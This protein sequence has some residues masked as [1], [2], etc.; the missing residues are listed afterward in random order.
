MEYWNNPLTE[1]V[2][3]SDCDPI[4]ESFHN[5]KH[6]IFWN[7]ETKFDNIL[8]NQRLGDLCSWAQAQLDHNGLD[9]FV[10]D[11]RNHYDIANLV[12]CN[13]WIH[14]IRSQGIV[15]PW[16]ML[17]LGDGTFIAGTGDSRLRCLERIPEISTV[18]GFISTTTA[19][20]HLYSD[21]EPVT[22]FDQYA[23]LCKA[24]PG[25]R[26]LFRL[27]DPTAP[28][29]VYWYEYDSEQTRLVTPGESDAVSMFYNYAK[30][31]PGLQITPEWFDSKITW[32]HHRSN[33]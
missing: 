11:Q 33:S 30:L 4:V 1:V 2:W 21:L 10:Q 19:R 13:L 12:K 6:C 14:D 20:A 32:E 8:T 25:Q 18:A 17:D 3:P 15:K 22:S 29:G 23:K 26:F 5:G 9:A 27:T 31:N 7:P 16:L 24:V 28:F